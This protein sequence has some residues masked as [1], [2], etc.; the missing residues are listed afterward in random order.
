[1]QKF[2]QNLTLIHKTAESL[3][4]HLKNSFN[5]SENKKNYDFKK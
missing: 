4:K 5:D 2:M 3:L 1:M